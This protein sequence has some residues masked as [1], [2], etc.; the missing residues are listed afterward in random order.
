MRRLVTRATMAVA[1][2]VGAATAPVTPSTA[3]TVGALTIESVGIEGTVSTKYPSAKASVNTDQMGHFTIDYHLDPES[4]PPSEILIHAEGENA[5]SGIAYFPVT[6]TGLPDGKYWVRGTIT[7]SNEAGTWTGTLESAPFGAPSVLVDRTSPTVTGIDPYAPLIRPGSQTVPQAAVITAYGD[8]GPGDHFVLLRSTGR[9]VT[10]LDTRRS[11]GESWSTEI[12]GTVNSVGLSSG[13]YTVVLSDLWGNRT[14]L[15][16]TIQVQRLV[17]RTFIQTMSA[18]RSKAYSSVGRCSTLATPASRGWSGS[19]A[20]NSNTK[21]RKTFN[22]GLVVTGH[23]MYIPHRDVTEYLYFHVSTYSG[24]G[25][26]RPRSTAA[27]LYAKKN[28]DVSEPSF[29]GASLK[30]R[31]GSDYAAP[32]FILRD[33]PGSAPYVA[34]YVAS[35]RGNRYDI[36]NFTVTLSYRVWV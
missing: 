10:W 17:T 2:A 31:S 36:K 1:L 5:F 21:C 26:S 8:A 25:R 18:T 22:A 23:G 9:E 34:W 4:G 33:S 7:V 29:L 27:L 20:L 12:R 13:T 35:S 16:V 30:D 32:S 15:G 11:R 14:D 19:L 3:E 28:G 6:A 24:A